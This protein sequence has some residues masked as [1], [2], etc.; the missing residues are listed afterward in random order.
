MQVVQRK[1]RKKTGTMFEETCNLIYWRVAVWIDRVRFKARLGWNRVFNPLR[2][3]T[4]LYATYMILGKNPM[5][6]EKCENALIRLPY[7]ARRHIHGLCAKALF[8]GADDD[9]CE[10]LFNYYILGGTE[11]DDECTN[12]K[13]Q[14][15]KA[16]C[17]LN[18]T[19][20]FKET[21]QVSKHVSEKL[22]K[23]PYEY[24]RAM[25]KKQRRKLEK[26]LPD[27]HEVFRRIKER[28]PEH[29]PEFWESLEKAIE[30]EKKRKAFNKIF[31]V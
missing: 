15:G 23:I 11:A 19:D 21:I 8:P 26:Q 12:Y 18:G 24:G 27:L 6:Q 2:H 22:R 1:T 25:T 31:H 30:R 29:P 9:F 4:L 17:N 7:D 10:Y 5:D 28:H 3:A 13:N 14:I 16:S 20:V